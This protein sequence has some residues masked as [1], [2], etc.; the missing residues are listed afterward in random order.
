MKILL[1]AGSF[2]LLSETFV[3]YQAIGLARLGS[4]VT[5]LSI[6]RSTDSLHHHAYE[7]SH[8][9]L[10]LVNTNLPNRAR[11]VPLFLAPALVRVIRKF[12]LTAV[13]KVLSLRNKRELIHSIERISILAALP[14]DEY[15]IIYCHFGPNGQV[16]AS[17]KKILHYHAGL[18]TVFHGYDMSDYVIRGEK[19][20]N[21]LFE[22]G[23]LFLPICDFWKSKLISIGCPE[24]KVMTLHL[25]VDTESIDF[26]VRQLPQNEPIKFLTVAR[27]ITNKGHAVALQ[28]LATL[29]YEWFY[30][31]VGDGPLNGELQELAISLKIAERVN[32]VGA[33]SHDRVLDYMKRSDIVVLSSLTAPNGESEGLPVVLMEA[34]ACGI[35]VISTRLSGIPELVENYWSGVLVSENSVPELREG[36]RWLLSHPE[37]WEGL[38]QNARKTVE[39]EF[40]AARQL[41][42]LTATLTLTSEVATQQHLGS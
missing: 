2:P 1:V 27:L 14:D 25:G 24:H 16:M 26:T 31:I 8:Q 36:F 42:R 20:Y 18:V 10:R 22:I 32:F 11:E 9:H 4:E 29:D 12:G 15:D 37:E 33:Q 41:A 39:R 34:M 3:L 6:H 38:E 21:E 19:Q 5:V 30:T 35:P 40:N 7:I 13:L 23:D 17:L 28:A